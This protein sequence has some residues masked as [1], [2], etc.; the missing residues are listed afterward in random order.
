METVYSPIGLGTR[1]FGLP[2]PVGLAWGDVLF[3]S[4]T[5]SQVW[6]DFFGVCHLAYRVRP[7]PRPP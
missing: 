1:V 4:E 5:D 3:L 2:P 6:G 7:P